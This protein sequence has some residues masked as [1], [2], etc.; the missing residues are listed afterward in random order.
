MT[1]DLRE[2]P[3]RRALSVF[4]VTHRQLAD[5]VRHVVRDLG[6]AL[7]LLADIRRTEHFVD[8]LAHA[9]LERIHVLANLL[10]ALA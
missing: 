10:G 5:E 9:A 2:R 1:L 6:R 7:Q 8:V 3:G 4:R